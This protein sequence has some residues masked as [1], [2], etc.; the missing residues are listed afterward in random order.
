ML[1]VMSEYVQDCV[2]CVS[3]CCCVDYFGDIYLGGMQLIR[4]NF[5]V[6][7]DLYVSFGVLVECVVVDYCGE[8]FDDVVFEYLVDVVFYCWS[9]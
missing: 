5:V 3:Y 9:G 8:V 1:Y 4:C 6:V 7:E 2:G